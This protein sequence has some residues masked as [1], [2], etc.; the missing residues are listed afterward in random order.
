MRREATGHDEVTSTVGETGIP[1]H[2]L[3]L[4]PGCWVVAVGCSPLAAGGKANPLQAG[5]PPRPLREVGYGPSGHAAGP[6]GLAPREF[7]LPLEHLLP[8][9][10]DQPRFSKSLLG[11]P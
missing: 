1:Q 7:S 11:L 2:W 4:N 8:E 3:L 6:I 10:Q 9:L 5:E